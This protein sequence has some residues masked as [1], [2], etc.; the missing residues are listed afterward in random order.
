MFDDFIRIRFAPRRQELARVAPL[1]SSAPMR[2]LQM[3]R[4]A[5]CL[6]VCLLVSTC[7]SAFLAFPAAPANALLARQ[8]ICRTAQTAGR[9]HRQTVF[10]GTYIGLGKFRKSWGGDGGDKKMLEVATDGEFEILLQ[11]GA[12]AGK[13]IVA[14]FYASWCRQVGPYPSMSV[15]ISEW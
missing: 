7:E 8:R 1:L 2:S 10:A 4:L 9:G 11:R 15:D 13:L 6:T 5:L 3:A 14:D 12:D